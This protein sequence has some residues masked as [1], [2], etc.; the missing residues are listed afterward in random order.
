[1]IGVSKG[2]TI[3]AA[4]RRI[5]LVAEATRDAGVGGR[6]AS[7]INGLRWM[8]LVGEGANGHQPEDFGSE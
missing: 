7:G 1:M 4:E 6:W 5:S 3:G 2:G 8:V